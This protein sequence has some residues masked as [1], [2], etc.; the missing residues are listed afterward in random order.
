MH[1]CQ[2]T[3][4][5]TKFGILTLISEIFLDKIRLRC[6]L[7]TGKDIRMIGTA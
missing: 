4:S 1:F 7:N 5:I 3:R 6:Y 2:T